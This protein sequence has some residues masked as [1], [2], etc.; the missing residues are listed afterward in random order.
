MRKWRQIPVPEERGFLCKHRGGTSGRIR[1]SALWLRQG[2]VLVGSWWREFI[3]HHPHS[4]G[5]P[6]L[7]PQQP[8]DAANGQGAVP[9]PQIFLYTV[10]RDGE[11]VEK[12]TSW[13]SEEQA[14]IV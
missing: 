10:S 4:L 2:P 13:L 3:Q 11:G 5:L 8:V 12:P 6:Q 1:E 7:L 9:H 14:F